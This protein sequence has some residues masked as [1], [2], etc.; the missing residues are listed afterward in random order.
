M[1]IYIYI[2]IKVKSATVVEGDPKA[3]FSLANT[4]RY[5]EGHYFSFL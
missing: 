4:P 5:R 1:Y 2:Y 3:L